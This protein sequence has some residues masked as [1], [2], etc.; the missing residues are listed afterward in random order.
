LAELRA[1]EDIESSSKQVVPSWIGFATHNPSGQRLLVVNVN[2]A[3][4]ELQFKHSMPTIIT[5]PVIKGSIPADCKKGGSAFRHFG[6]HRN[7]NDLLQVIEDV[8][9]GKYLHKYGSVD[10]QG[11]QKGWASELTLDDASNGWDSG[12]TVV[13]AYGGGVTL[14]TALYAGSID[15]SEGGSSSD[16]RVQ[17]KSKS[18]LGRSHNVWH[19]HLYVHW[20]RSTAEFLNPY[21][22]DTLQEILEV[23][24][25][26]RINPNESGST[27]PPEE[28]TLM[29]PGPVK[30]I[31]C[32]YKK[33]VSDYYFSNS[34]ERSPQDSFCAAYSEKW[35]HEPCDWQH[36]CVLVASEMEQERMHGTAGEA[37]AVAVPP[38]Q[39]LILPEASL[40]DVVR[41]TLVVDGPHEVE[42]V[43]Q[44]LT[45]YNDEPEH[46]HFKVVAV[47]NQYHEDCTKKHFRALYLTVQYA[48]SNTS[49]SS[50]SMHP[51]LVPR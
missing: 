41:C 10:G 14:P 4:K 28:G 38:P 13:D 42:D 50:S 49:S 40:T 8:E 1:I 47:K 30:W 39:K 36:A 23:P 5:D 45:A 12:A 35:G 6:G 17:G 37:T 16:S 46:R 27:P 15:G 26:F 20:L 29:I 24:G 19:G 21:F 32:M 2:E 11:E 3:S 9:A 33:A 43:Y 18:S 44:R 31:E 7:C 51:R 34:G 48:Y 22:Q 25:A